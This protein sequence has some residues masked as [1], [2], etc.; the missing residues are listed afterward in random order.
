MILRTSLVAMTALDRARIFDRRASNGP[1]VESAVATIITAVRTRGDDALFALARQFDNAELDALEVPRAVIEDALARL[2]PTV[3]EAL[4]EAAAAIRTF[5]AA[6]LS[7]DL[8]VEARP[9]VRLGRRT[10]PLRRVGVYA[11]GGTAAYPSS[12]LMGV[13][14]ARVAGVEDVVVCSPPDSTG[15]PSAVV[16]AACAIGGVTRVFAAGGAGAVAAM[17]YGTRTIP[18]VAKI[19]GPGN[20]Y[21]AEAKRQL[22]GIV[23]ID[24]P[25]GPSEILVIA[26]ATAD[27]D[28][29]ALELIAQA[30]HDTNASAIALFVNAP[31]VCAGVAGAIE[32]IVPGQPRRQIIAAALSA[33][34]ALVDVDS[35][36]SALAL[37]EE[38]APEHLSLMVAGAADI[39]RDVRAAGTI[40]VGAASSV[41]FGDYITG[42]N[43]V[44][45][46]AGLARC[47]SGLAVEDFSRRVTWQEISADAAHELATPTRV[48]AEAEGLPAHALAA[49]ARL[50]PTGTHDVANARSV[51]TRAA[52]AGIEL[53]EPGRRPCA[54]DLSDNTNLEGTAPS[55]VAIL[56]TPSAELVSRYPSVYGSRL[57][58][59]IARRYGIGPDN[60][61]TGC[62]SDDLLDAILRAFCNPGDTVAF[63]LPT[64][65]VIDLFARMNAAVPAA[66]RAADSNAAMTLDVSGLIAQSA[67]VTYVCRPN[68]P[69]GTACARDAIAELCT[70]TKGVLAIDEA[71]ADYASDNCMDLAL[72]SD[73]T[74]VLRTMS[75]AYGLAGLRIGYAVGPQQ[76]VRE[77]EK[78]RGPYKLGALAEAAAVA[79]LE[80]DATWIGA[81]V[82]RTIAAR[83][84][85]AAQLQTLGYAPF[86]SVANFL[87]IP[88]PSHTSAE[89]AAVLRERGVAVRAFAGLAG[90]GDAI[91]VT[92]GPMSQMTRFLDA[93]AY[94]SA[95]LPPR[96]LAGSASC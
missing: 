24:S 54:I 21:V 83:D 10:E 59:A 48:L 35:L 20:A 1:A 88:L 82:R 85:V 71:Y 60:V 31:D 9:G 92:V 94:V 27:A 44:L 64:F 76:I 91:R 47:W 8:V 17:A 52:Y 53:Y 4:E 28:L 80:N 15:V 3:R 29:V 84:H 5:H 61:A 89:V 49:T 38:Y 34:G 32:R 70:R 67:A 73:R 45:P 75:K 14:P 62:G 33:R 25:A 6:Q 81:H 22:S 79:A 69:T 43:H 18:R 51:R 46:T 58:R 77:I 74:L 30:E 90:I 39:V 63:Q 68:N 11:P 95:S 23:G 72:Q 40:F 37:A 26:D 66:L 86:P 78:A 36:A 96:T 16:L 41:A 19:V 87:L 2:D 93:M 42:A 56:D 57:K 13:I 55:A 50:R 12:V 7:A 65:G